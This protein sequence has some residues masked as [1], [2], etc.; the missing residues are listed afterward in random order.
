MLLGIWVGNLV[1][2]WAGSLGIC[3]GNL[4]IWVG[5]PCQ[6]CL[7]VGALLLFLHWANTSKIQIN[8]QHSCLEW[9]GKHN[10]QCKST[11]TM[12]M[13]ISAIKT[14]LYK[15][16][17]GKEG[18]AGR[19]WGWSR[20]QGLHGSRSPQV[21]FPWLWGPVQLFYFLTG[22][23]GTW[24]LNRVP[25]SLIRV[26]VQRLSVQEP[27]YNAWW[28]EVWKLDHPQIW[29]LRFHTGN[30][31]AACSWATEFRADFRAIMPMVCNNFGQPWQPFKTF[32][33]QLSSSVGGWV[34]GT[35][36]PTPTQVIVFN[37]LVAT[38]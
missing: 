18:Q 6:L 34:G 9:K 37:I 8:I 25:G 12:I 5:N 20:I 32:W 33:W 35:M 1:G 10:W 21:Q 13:I 26:S 7:V 3:V 28:R 19:E 17:R 15:G 16:G 14:N 38:Q 4:V 22:Y 27:R 11:M 30:K 31:K 24:F 29:K 36:A 2:I 23:L